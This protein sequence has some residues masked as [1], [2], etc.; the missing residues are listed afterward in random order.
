M[1]DVA[2]RGDGENMIVP[3]SHDT[4]EFPAFEI[5]VLDLSRRPPQARAFKPVH[6][7]QRALSAGANWSEASSMSGEV[8]PS[9]E[10]KLLWLDDSFRSCVSVL[11]R[12]GAA[13]VI[14]RSATLMEALD[15]GRRISWRHF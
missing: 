15:E 4:T 10:L 8:D 2:P 11:G 12:S 14:G 1:G 3:A 7:S 6:A 13:I 5:G 9:E